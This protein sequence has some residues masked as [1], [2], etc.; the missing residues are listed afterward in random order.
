MHAVEYKTLTDYLKSWKE[1]EFQ[2]VIMFG[3]SLEDQ[4]FILS[5]FK[6]K[7]FFFLLNL[8]EKRRN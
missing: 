8:F 5:L 2:T 7:F 6:E 3:A 1:G 4:V